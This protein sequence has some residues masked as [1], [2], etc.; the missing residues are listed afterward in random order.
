MS[1]N[2]TL[3]ARLEP[4]ASTSA[5]GLVQGHVSRPTRVLTMLANVAGFCMMRTGEGSACAATARAAFPLPPASLL[6]RLSCLLEQIA[7][8]LKV[9]QQR[10]V[11]PIVD[12]PVPLAEFV[13]V[14]EQI[15]DVP[16]LLTMEDDFGVVRFTL[17]ERVQNRT[18][19]QTVDS[20]MPQITEDGLPIVPQ[21]RVQN[22]TPE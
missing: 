11:E 20:S 8:V 14:W 15:V 6:A 18:Q 9:I 16:V 2:E 5:V 19:E 3:V 1:E 17:Q 10:I 21:E 7:E 22:H 13:G 12:E 4:M